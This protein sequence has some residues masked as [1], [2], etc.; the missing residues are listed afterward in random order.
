MALG[1]PLGL[2]TERLAATPRRDALNRRGWPDPVSSHGET[3]RVPTA[4]SGRRSPV[5]ATW[6]ASCAGATRSGDDGKGW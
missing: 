6:G 4:A 3:L 2:M 1:A 5:G